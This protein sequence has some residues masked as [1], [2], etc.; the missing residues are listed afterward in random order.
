MNDSKKLRLALKANAGFSAFSG[1]VLIF[2]HRPIAGFMG[3]SDGTALWI[4]GL[5]LLVFV[6]SLWRNATRAEIDRKQVRLIILQDWLWVLGSATLI[7][8]Q[9]FGIS[10]GGYLAIGLVALI[11]ADFA[12]LQSIFLKKM[13]V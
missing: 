11:V 9:A 10:P 6:F 4:I 12:V 13:P 7:I 3:L 1:L 8:L 5:G 2:F